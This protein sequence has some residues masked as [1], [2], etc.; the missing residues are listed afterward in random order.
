MREKMKKEKEIEVPT[1][2]REEQDNERMIMYYTIK[3]R[4]EENSMQ[5]LRERE[6]YRNLEIA[7]LQEGR[8]IN[9]ISYGSCSHTPQ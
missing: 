7:L 4:G 3:R 1:S 8:H 5:S 9:K 2:T 6:R